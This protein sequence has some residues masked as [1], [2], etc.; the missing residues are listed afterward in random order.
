MTDPLG[1]ASIDYDDTPNCEKGRSHTAHIKYRFEV[2]CSAVQIR[3]HSRST[4]QSNVIVFDARYSEMRRWFK[5]LCA[6][7]LVNPEKLPPFPSKT[8]SLKDWALCSHLDVNSTLVKR[9]HKELQ[10]LLDSMLSCYPALLNNK[11][12]LKFI[13]PHQAFPPSRPSFLKAEPP[14]PL[15]DA[16]ATEEGQGLIVHHGDCGGGL[17]SRAHCWP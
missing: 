10:G 16:L 15:P 13:L 3:R 11:E 2:Q 1:L 4:W 6:S 8:S 7:G 9:R 12:A 14:P 17:V 5:S